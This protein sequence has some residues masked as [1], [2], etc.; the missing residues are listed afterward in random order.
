MTT[1]EAGQLVLTLNGVELPTTVSGRNVGST[2]IVGVN[3]V[4][5]TIPNSTLTVRNPLAGTPMTLSLSVVP[6]TAQLMITRV[7]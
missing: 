5:T 4:T 3:M 7:N 6:L 1:E 2:Q